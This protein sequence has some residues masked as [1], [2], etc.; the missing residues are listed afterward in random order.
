MNENQKIMC[1]VLILLAVAVG[2]YLIVPN[3]QKSYE[4][5]KQIQEKTQKVQNTQAEI[6]KLKSA[7]EAYDKEEKAQTKPVYKS[8]LA[9]M[10]QMATFGIMFEDVIQS[11]KY[12][13]LR[14]RSISYNTNPAGDVVKANVGDLYNVCEV[15]MQLIGSYS[16]FKSYFQDI[17][18]YPYLINLDKISI[19][20]YAADPKVLIADVSVMLYS[21]MNDVQ[22]A[23]AAAAKAAEMQGDEAVEGGAGAELAPA[24]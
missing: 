7:K 17:Y 19:F 14:L 23:A 4:T 11:A 21:E 18:N 22:K 10:D 20:P 16:Q 2:L 24:Q 8:D 3:A 13:G 1:I 12:N 5:Y 15:K 6:D 9:T